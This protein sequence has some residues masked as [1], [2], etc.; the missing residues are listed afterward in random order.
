MSGGPPMLSEGEAAPARR[1]T[2]TP[3]RRRLGSTTAA[4][5]PAA[6]RLRRRARRARTPPPRCSSAVA[7]PAARP[8]AADLPSTPSAHAA[9]TVLVGRGVAG[10]PADCRGSSSCSSP[11]PA[12]TP[13]A[14]AA[15]TVLAGR[16]VAGSRR[17]HERRQ[18]RAKV[19]RDGAVRATRDARADGVRRPDFLTEA[20]FEAAA[21]L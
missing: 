12:S 21:R 14:H 2:P 3:A 13:S 1:P 18:C 17:R 9:A 10:R 15:A 11:P 16:G 19:A 8:A 7:W 5:P 6:A 20:P 4:D